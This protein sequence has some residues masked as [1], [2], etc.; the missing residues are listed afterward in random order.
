MLGGNFDVMMC[1]VG[2]GGLEDVA[3]EPVCSGVG[4]VGCVMGLVPLLFGAF[5]CWDRVSGVGSV[6]VGL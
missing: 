3:L 4:F 2:G 1:P 6:W 5:G